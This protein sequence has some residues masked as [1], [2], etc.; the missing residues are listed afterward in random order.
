MINGAMRRWL[1]S[2]E[3]V[4]NLFQHLPVAKVKAEYAALRESSS[5]LR[6][7]RLVQTICALRH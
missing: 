2:E 4:L 3:V 5:N 6:K 1:F 7:L